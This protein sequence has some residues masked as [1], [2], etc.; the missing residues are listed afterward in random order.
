MAGHI[1]S[2]RLEDVRTQICFNLSK[3]CTNSKERRAIGESFIVSIRVILNKKKMLS[4]VR[5]VF[6]GP[7]ERNCNI[8]AMAIAHHGRQGSKCKY[9]KNRKL[10]PC[11]LALDT[12]GS[13]K[14][15]NLIGQYIHNAYRIYTMSTFDMLPL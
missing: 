1:L 4:F 15:D 9:N 14:K 2:I 7:F 12:D 10:Y 5:D 3:S 13:A 6:E 11:D 8:C